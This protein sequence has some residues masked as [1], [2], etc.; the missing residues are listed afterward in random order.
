MRLK[1]ATKRTGFPQ[2]RAVL[3]A[4]NGDANIARTALN[5]PHAFLVEQAHM[6]DICTRPKLASRTCPKSFIYGPGRLRSR[7]C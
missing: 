7:R 6:G 1:G 4:R 5:L 3:E 2:L